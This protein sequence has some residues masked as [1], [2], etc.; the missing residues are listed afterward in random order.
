MGNINLNQI[1]L[2]KLLK[3]TNFGIYL[4]AFFLLVCS[5]SFDVYTTYIATPDLAKELNV[6]VRY[7]RFGWIDLS[8]MNI[9]IILIFSILFIL[10]WSH[11]MK[12]RSAKRK[13]TFRPFEKY[14][15][16]G[17]EIAWNKPHG[18]N[19]PRERNIPL[20]LGLTL[21]I[22]VIITGFF[23]GIVNLL[24]HLDYIIISSTFFVYLYPIIIGLIFGYL[25]LF[26]SKRI[27]YSERIKHRRKPHKIL[28][29]TIVNTHHDDWVICLA[30]NQNDAKEV[31]VGNPQ[32][33]GCNARFDQSFNHF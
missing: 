18:L 1:N 11:H 16:G 31:M 13:S 2:H 28:M 27:L 6:V 19:H 14:A 9:V 22:Y 17:G 32:H 24:I 29:P 8:I 4:T 33:L 30:E 26:L 23:Q 3:D 7:F 5:R 12:I 20:E 21:P 15:F 25:S 10:S